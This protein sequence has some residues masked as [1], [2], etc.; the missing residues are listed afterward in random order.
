MN[1][2]FADA[3]PSP[4]LAAHTGFLLSWSGHR[5]RAIFSAELAPLGLGPR[6]FGVLTTIEGLP[7]ATQQDLVDTSRIDSST[8][9]SV[10]DDL[11]GLGLAERRPH[12]DD[13][14]KSAV[15]LTGHGREVLAE[16]RA[17]AGRARERLLAPLDAAERETL[18]RLLRKVAGLDGP[19]GA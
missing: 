10:L 18:H 13:R 3:P 2:S 4:A 15:H 11:E 17:A 12:A 7:G 14:R 9:V 8:M 5:A 1:V 19:A 16:G 6:H